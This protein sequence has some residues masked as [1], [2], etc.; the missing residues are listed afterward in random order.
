MHADYR[1]IRDLIPTPPLWFDEFGVPRYRR[2]SPLLLANIYAREC[3]FVRIHCQACDREFHVAVSWSDEPPSTLAELIQSN[4]LHYGDPPN[5]DCC[6]TGPTMSSVPRKIME[7]WS[8]EGRAR[9]VALK[10]LPEGWHSLPQQKA[11][12]MIAA[13]VAELSEEQ[14][15]DWDRHEE[16]EVAV[17]ARW[18]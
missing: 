10:A 5:V 9:A 2:F 18:E 15:S 16:L 12:E 11:G 4:R 3:A 7:Y 17:Q 13:A 6:G 14:R 1:D 8:R